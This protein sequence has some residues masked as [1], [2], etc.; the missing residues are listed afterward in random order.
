[1]PRKSPSTVI[2]PNAPFSTH[3]RDQDFSLGCKRS[4]T[5]QNKHITANTT[6]QSTETQMLFLLENKNFIMKWNRTSFL[7]M[8]NFPSLKIPTTHVWC[9]VTDEMQKLVS[10]QPGLTESELWWNRHDIFGIAPSSEQSH[11]FVSKLPAPLNRC[12]RSPHW[13]PDPISHSVWVEAG[14]GLFSVTGH[15]L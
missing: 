9:Y 8:H 11:Y 4:Y 6:L 14:T 1:M 3:R 5:T 2:P 10:S 7:K 13:P 12:Q 15:I